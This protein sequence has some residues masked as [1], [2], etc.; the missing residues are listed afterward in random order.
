MCPGDQ[1]CFVNE[2]EESFQDGREEK[3]REKRATEMSVGGRGL[4]PWGSILESLEE[5]RREE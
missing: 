2:R 1:P 3:E 5:A 4:G